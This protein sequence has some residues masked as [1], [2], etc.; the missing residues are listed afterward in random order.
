MRSAPL[1]LTVALAVCLPLLEHVT[2]I[3]GGCSLGPGG[4]EVLLHG[5]ELRLQFAGS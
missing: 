5:G 1:A 3:G 4:F 2:R